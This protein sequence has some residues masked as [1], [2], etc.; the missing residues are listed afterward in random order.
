MKID[1]LV[2]LEINELQKS[3]IK[4]IGYTRL[5]CVNYGISSTVYLFWKKDGLTFIQKYS[6]SKYNDDSLDKSKQIQVLESFFF[7]FYRKN[8]E[9]LNSENVKHFEYK[10]DSI[11]N[12][13]LYSYRLMW[14]H[15]CSR[16]FV[17]TV[18]YTHLTLPTSDLV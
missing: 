11:K 14:S 9:E 12:N 3:G 16:H 4:E 1:S 5:T 2:N 17:I 15:S 8:K 7:D 10:P 13:K 6:N 18:S